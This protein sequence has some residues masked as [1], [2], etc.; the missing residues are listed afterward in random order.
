MI[1]NVPKAVV[2]PMMP[3]KS[4]PPSPAVSPARI[5]KLPVDEPLSIV[6][7]NLIAPSKLPSVS[8]VSIVTLPS[9]NTFP[10]RVIS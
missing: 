4:R 7:V 6:L 8:S 9:T 2:P 10:V 5:V 3:S 1:F